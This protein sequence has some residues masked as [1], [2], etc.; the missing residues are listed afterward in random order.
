MNIANEKGV[1]TALSYTPYGGEVV[2]IETLLYPGERKV[3][4]TGQIGE[5]MEESI[6]VALAYNKGNYEKFKLDL[7]EIRENTIHIHIP[8]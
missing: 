4:I 3:K 1:I 2:K 6:Q 8:V 7:N 5:V